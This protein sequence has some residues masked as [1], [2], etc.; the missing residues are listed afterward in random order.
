MGGA[1]MKDDLI[2]YDFR[3]SGGLR[4]AAQETRRVFH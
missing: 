4:R 3:R 1:L 2:V